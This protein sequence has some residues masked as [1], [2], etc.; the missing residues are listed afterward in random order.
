MP[1][2][3]RLST[4][5]LA[6]FLVVGLPSIGYA[7]EGAR[8]T[9][10]TEASYK[11]SSVETNEI[12]RW[13]AQH[14]RYHDGAMIG[15]PQRLGEVTVVVTRSESRAGAMGVSADQPLKSLPSDGANGDQI[16]ITSVD[17][18]VSQEWDYIW[19]DGPS[20]DWVLVSYQTSEVASNGFPKSGD[21]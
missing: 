4:A 15:D 5:L 17:S 6:G 13:L 7:D 10:T 18:D 3:K 14:G 8:R 9:T 11:A 19:R 2:G 1:Y 16:S 20:G 21:S 12:Q